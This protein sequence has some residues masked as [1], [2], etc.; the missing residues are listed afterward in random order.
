[1]RAV[2]A[3]SCASAWRRSGRRS[4]RS[5]GRPTGTST[6]IGTAGDPRSNFASYTS[7]GL[8]PRST[9]SAPSCA[10][11]AWRATGTSAA[12]PRKSDST[13]RYSTS[14]TAPASRRSF[15]T[16][17]ALRRRARDHE[18]GARL[19]DALGGGAQV[20]VGGERLVD[21]ALERRIAEDAPPAFCRGRG[22]LRDAVVLRQVDVGAFVVGADGAAGEEHRQECQGNEDDGDDRAAA[23]ATRLS[24]RIP[25]FGA[26]RESSRA[27][28]SAPASRDD[29]RLPP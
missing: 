9:A 3:W 16:S 20:A 6:T 28:A 27:A 4:S 22:R 19:L 13:W 23:V 18:L 1:M 7:R 14:E 26:C 2:A 25:P 12:V 10:T 17:S 29:A 5:E 21:E 15:C 11:R 8:R 24:H